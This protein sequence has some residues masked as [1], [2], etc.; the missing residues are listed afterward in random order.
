MRHSLNNIFNY[1]FSLKTFAKA[2]LF[3]AILTCKAFSILTFSVKANGYK[4]LKVYDSYKYA[5]DTEFKRNEKERAFQTVLEVAQKK[6]FDSFSSMQMRK[7]I[8]C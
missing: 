5:S 2:F 3:L 4:N 1:S 6:T 7:L 8:L